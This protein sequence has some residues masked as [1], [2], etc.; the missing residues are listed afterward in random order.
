M[1]IREIKSDNF[2]IYLSHDELLLLNNAV[3]EV[4]NGIEAR[5]FSTR[6]GSSREE[7]LAILSEI[8]RALS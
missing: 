6:I 2:T 3:N 7:A 1:K 5:E 4:C 8:G